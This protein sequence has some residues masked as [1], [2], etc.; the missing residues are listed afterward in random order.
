VACAAALLLCVPRGAHAQL[1]EILNIVE[2]IQSRVNTAITQAQAARVAAEEVRTQ[3]RQGADALTPELRTFVEN[4]ITEARTILEEEADGLEIF[5]PGGQCDTVCEA[6]RT[7]LLESLTGSIELTF[8]RPARSCRWRR[9]GFCIRS[10]G[11]SKGCSGPVCANG[12]ARS[13]PRRAP[14]FP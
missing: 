2:N 12:S 13:G 9:R 11:C 4:A 8:R 6:F 14:W 5:A 10:T 7:D 3:V 1:S